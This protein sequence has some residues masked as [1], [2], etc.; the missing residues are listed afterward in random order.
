MP[1]APDISVILKAHRPTRDSP[2]RARHVAGHRSRLGRPLSIPGRRADRRAATPG[3]RP[4]PPSPQAGHARQRA[5]S[6]AVR[7]KPTVRTDRPGGPDAVRYASVDTATHRLTVTHR[8]TRRS[9]KETAR[10]AENS[11]VAGRFRR[12]WQV[13]CLGSGHR[14]QGV[15]RHPGHSRRASGRGD[16]AGQTLAG[17]RK[18][19]WSSPPSPSR[20]AR[21]ARWRSPTASPARWVSA[22]LARYQAEGEAAFEPRSRRPKTSPTAISDDRADLIIELRKELSGQGLDAGRRPSPGTR[23]APPARMSQLPPSAGT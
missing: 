9:K 23:T 3:A 5:P 7:G 1:T 4:A 10:V 6:V 18:P 8:D 16:L 11:P 20:S 15:S 13:L 21:S 14:G 2:S 22:L 19:G 12:W 17:C